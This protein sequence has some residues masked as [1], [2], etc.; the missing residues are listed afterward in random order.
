M[1]R[2]D[3]LTPE[4]RALAALIGPAEP[5]APSAAVDAAVLAAARA[6]LAADS[7]DSAADPN[8]LQPATSGL[9]RN[10]RH[11]LP[12]AGSTT[13][14]RLRRRSRWPALT[15]IAASVVFAVGVAWQLQ[16]EGPQIPDLAAQASA[17][18][19]AAPAP[20]P[21]H[22]ET[23]AAEPLPAQ[24]DSTAAA[25]P[26]AAASAPRRERAAPPAPVA[27]PRAE[28]VQDAGRAMAPPTPAPAPSLMAD[29]PAAGQ[30]RTRAAHVDAIR[31]EGAAADERASN[32]ASLEKST[33][34]A[35]RALSPAPASAPRLMRAPPEAAAVQEDAAPVPQDLAALVQDDARLPRRQWLL[36]IRQ[37]R[38]A[39]EF[40]AAR[41]SLER[42]LQ[43]YP[44]TPLPADLR[45]LLDR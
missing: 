1:S 10:A 24:A 29:D 22:T 14:R 36:K 26:S 37:R 21:P 38:D 17:V 23:T 39:G 12:D 45:A 20:A 28:P 32:E 25:V 35:R 18:E 2:H 13:H 16:P 6:A 42:Y 15:G 44:G 30:D 40:D 8:P 5:S 27:V 43:D 33:P 41:A 9:P 7:K 3:P 19:Q 34:M 11:A 4:E 31:Q